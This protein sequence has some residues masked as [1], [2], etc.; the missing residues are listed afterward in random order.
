MATTA[1]APLQ[2]PAADVQPAGEQTATDDPWG[3]Q[4]QD[5]WARSW[6]PAPGDEATT[7]DQGRDQ[8]WHNRG[9]EWR[10]SR[11]ETD[12]AWSDARWSDGWHHSGGQ[13]WSHSGGQDWSQDAGS[14]TTAGDNGASTDQSW[15]RRASDSWDSRW[16]ASGGDGR[17]RDHQQWR[18]SGETGRDEAT[19]DVRKGTPSERMAVPTFSADASGDDLGT[20]ARSY[21]RQVDAWIK[22]TRT[23]PDQRALIL[24]QNLAGR[25][26]V[27]AEE[28]DVERLASP[29]GVDF[30]RKW[31]QERYQ[32]VE[33]SKIAEALT[34]FFK[35]MKRGPGQSIR[36]FNSSFD[37]AYTRLLEIDCK[38]PEVAR[39]WAYLHAMGLTASEELAL[40]ASVG[41][42]YSPSRLQKAAIMHEKSL[43]GPWTFRKGPGAPGG[44]DGRRVT[45]A[46]LTGLAGDEDEEEDDDAEAIPEELACELHEAYVAQE[47]AKS[48]YKDLVKSRGFDMDAN[49]TSGRSQD[50]TAAERLQLAKS[51][52]F[53]AG[54]KRRGHWHRD[55]E[56]PLNGGGGRKDPTS[57]TATSGSSAKSDG[58]AKGGHTKDSYVTH[59]A[60]VV[61]EV[62]TT[63]LMAITDC[64]CSKSV[65]GQAWLESYTKAAKRCGV[66]VPLH[67]CD[68]NF[69][70]G[71]S[72][73]FHA[74]FLATVTFQLGKSTV[75]IRVAIVNGE[76]PLLLSRSVLAELGMV[77]D[78][79]HHTADFVALDVFK[80]RL[81]YTETGHPALPVNPQKA[82]NFVFPDPQ[83]WGA[84]EIKIA[85]SRQ[86]QYTVFVM[87]EV[88]DV[89][90]DSRSAGVAADSVSS[91]LFFSKK[92]SAVVH[93]MLTADVLNPVLFSQWWS[94][95]NLSNDFWIETHDV[96]YR[97]H[98]SFAPQ[99]LSRL[100]HMAAVT[101]VWR[102]NK[103]DLISMAHE[104]GLTIHEGWTIGEIRHIVIEHR[105]ANKS[106]VPKGLGKM[107]LQEL[108]EKATE[109][110]I[111]YKPDAPKGYLQLAIRDKTKGADE[112]IVCFGRYKNHLYREVPQNYLDWAVR[113]A[114]ANPNA[115]ADLKKLAAWAEGRKET[116]RSSSSVDPETVAVLP[117]EATETDSSE[118]S[119]WSMVN[120][121]RGDQLPI[122]PKGRAPLPPSQSSG[123]RGYKEDRA[124][125][126]QT[127]RAAE[128]KDVEQ[129]TPARM[130]Q[131]VPEEIKSE[132]DAEGGQDGVPY[133]NTGKRVLFNLSE[134]SCMNSGPG[135][136]LSLGGDKRFGSSTTDGGD[137]SSGPAGIL[138]AGGDDS[139]LPEQEDFYDCHDGFDDYKDTGLREPPRVYEG[140]YSN[141]EFNEDIERLAKR[142]RQNELYDYQNAGELIKMLSVA[143]AGTEKREIHGKQATTLI[144][145]AYAYGAF[146]GL[147]RAT[148]QF[149]E[150]ARYLNNFLRRH[151]ASGDWSAI[152]VGWNLRSSLHRDPNNRPG[153]NSQLIA[154]GDFRGGRLWIE[155]NGYCS[156]T[157]D[158]QRATYKTEAGEEIEGAYHN[159]NGEIYDA[160]NRHY[161]EDWEGERFSISAYTPR[162]GEHLN[163][164][165]LDTLRALGF[166]VG[167]KR[168]GGRA[169]EVL[170]SRDV[171]RRDLRPRKGVRKAI[172]KNALKVYAMFTVMLATVTSVLSE[173]DVG[174]KHCDYKT[175]ILEIGGEDNTLAAAELGQSVV[176]PLS[177]T[178]FLEDIGLRQLRGLL[179]AFSP[180][181]LWVCEESGQV[182]PRHPVLE[183]GAAQLTRSGTFVLQQPLD[184]ATDWA[185]A[186]EDHF[187]HYDRETHVT[188]D[189]ITYVIR[190]EPPTEVPGAQTCFAVD[191]ERDGAEVPGPRGASAVSF[192]DTVP[193]HVQASL[194]RLHQ[195][196]GHPSVG[197]LVR[198]LKYAGAEESVLKA[199]KALKCQVCDRNK[200][201]HDFNSLVSVDVFHVFDAN[202]KRH[203]L[204]SIIDHATTY[205]IAYRLHGH[206]T[207]DYENAFVHGWGNTFGAPVTLS[208]DL[209]TGLQ[210]GLTRYAEFCGVRMRRSAGQ[211]HWQQGLVERHQMW[212]EDIIRRVIDEQAVTEEDIDMA[213]ACVNQAKNQL[214][215]RHGF[216]PS[217]AVFGKDPSTPGDLLAGQDEERFL[218]IMTA[219]RKRQKEINI[220]NPARVAF[221][222]SQTDARLRRALIQRARV[223]HTAYHIGEMVC[224]FRIEKSATKRGVWR[225][226]GVLVGCEGPTNWWVSYGGRC[227]LVAEE[228]LRPSTAEEL[229]ELLSTRVAKE[230]LDR[231][232]RNNPDDPEVFEPEDEN[233]KDLDLEDYEPSLVDDQDFEFKFP[234][235]DTEM[236]DSDIDKDLLPPE[237]QAPSSSGDYGPVPR[238]ITGKRSGGR[239]AP[240]TALMLKQ[241]ATERSREKQHEKELPWRLIPPSEHEGFKS[242]EDK[243]IREHLDSKALTP[244]SVEESA[245][246]EKTVHPSRILGSRW[247][248]RDK[249]Y[250]KRRVDESVPW[251][252][253]SRLVVF[254]HLDPDVGKVLTDAPT[255]NRL[256]ILTLLQFVASRLDDDEPW[257]ASAGDVTAAFL[258]GKQISRQL[259]MRQPRTGVRGMAPGAIFRIEK[260]IFGLVDSPR[261][262]WLELK[263][264]LL[265]LTV[266]HQGV[267]HHFKQS[268]LDPCVFILV[269][270]SDQDATPKA[271][272]G[273]HVDDLL[274]VGGSKLTKAIEK[275]LDAVL[276]IDEWEDNE[277]DYVGSHVK[278]TTEGVYVDQAAYTNSRLFQIDIQKGHL[279]TDQAT[280]EQA[281]DNRSLVGALSWLASQTRP[282]LQVSVSFAQQLQKDPTVADVK[283]TNAT[284]RRA[285]EFQQHGV[286][287]RKLDLDSLEILIFHDA[288]WANA[289][290]RDTGEDD[291][292]FVLSQEDHEKGFISGTPFDNKDRKPKKANSRVA[293]QYGLLVALGDRRCYTAEGGPISLVDWKSS[294]IQR[295]C[296][297]TFTAETMACTEGVEN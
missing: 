237:I 10:Q 249:N 51:R 273:V 190:V 27:E 186:F 68:E 268:I 214:R 290:P 179:D 209:E 100:S 188:D 64:A 39:A 38:L 194:T 80:Y 126:K 96:L 36:E 58:D 202:R 3:E 162:G 265:D 7:D 212:Y 259:F 233:E 197:D 140:Y 108:R 2:P 181:V 261:S 152:S 73:V 14:T 180:R 132:L 19:Q 262:W 22:V 270:S 224:F 183:A 146:Y 160:H 292:D 106:E 6:S 143:G 247:A 18:P 175:A 174:P 144:L 213:I 46:Y 164:I 191:R 23:A 35:R 66:E 170:P 94:E 34:H 185:E 79:A 235:G 32:E 215:R 102:A 165:Q 25:A 263:Q 236:L 282:D 279:D 198:H 234:A 92:V 72:R 114:A 254:G 242:A 184:N 67:N 33:V 97:I 207:Q 75:M 84:D 171:Q 95:T 210:A 284:A 88:C 216:S 297:S 107:T 255:I 220:R 226:P 26:W 163:Q 151:G 113:E 208:A 269:P 129:A 223:K 81:L 31:I 133:S 28:L 149:I 109:L 200:R 9:D 138:P 155:E 139:A 147:T 218:E 244:L 277:F 251:K 47:A 159:V 101:N 205:H 239:G 89:G 178:E 24:Y 199:A 219:D 70:F 231:L 37:R 167:R 227:H 131:D 281:I 287:L 82:P 30:Y 222:R 189:D 123:H 271:Y 12:N 55:P 63:E 119:K 291:P 154:F 16:G 59:V 289:L 120:E 250:S 294:A 241:A 229:N 41:N 225:G 260:G 4:T 62:P 21:L 145:G 245:E 182:L 124:T 252:H 135:D 99:V 52:S 228:H 122:K 125:N 286:W 295:V 77:F 118:M 53:C 43:K 11:W 56:C 156:A 117:Y 48:R 272:L 45:K 221:F 104:A 142:L 105:K 172:W 217:Q 29:D 177:T 121:W 243:Q 20:S 57:T 158:G 76:V 112:E 240:Y 169:D 211:A 264:I 266:E 201:T 42:E 13:D 116:S 90:P 49:A 161:V 276:P 137:M 150:A 296:R 267:V 230:D 17:G 65:A 134:G 246:I 74:N 168:K 136:G 258:N 192:P 1:E 288:A 187:R 293:S 274:L 285:M 15:C 153:T 238:R 278:V 173:F 60:Y 257:R 157:G 85:S 69:R 283:F 128:A 8:W 130:Q 91:R 111:H 127:R 83:E 50:R 253:K 110:G 78:M 54:C 115:S 206:S 280:A 44:Y 204:L 203:A 195:N 148:T 166:P 40:L 141:R 196:L 232:L 87:S 71:A 256:S 176:E 248:Y 61:G 93:N 86:Q 275:A 193:K 5:P 103:K 98:I